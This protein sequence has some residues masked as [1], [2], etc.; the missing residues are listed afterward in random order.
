MR[1]DSETTSDE[2]AYP[3][4]P[5]RRK[6]STDVMPTSIFLQI[7]PKKHT[8]SINSDTDDS[9]I[10]Q[11]GIHKLKLKLTD[12]ISWVKE[13]GEDYVA[14]ETL[15]GIE[16]ISVLIRVLMESKTPAAVGFKINHDRTVTISYQFLHHFSKDFMML[17]VGDNC[18]VFMN[19]F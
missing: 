12:E 11:E 14:L 17:K 3:A 8:H 6:Q 5:T 2:D 16:E 9:A 19:P 1:I 15:N 10:L 4:S 7:T 18:R 13:R